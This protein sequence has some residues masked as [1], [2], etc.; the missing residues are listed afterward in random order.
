[1]AKNINFLG[2]VT[3]RNQELV[4]QYP[5]VNSTVA[6]KKDV[7]DGALPYAEINR[8][9]GMSYRDA[10][11]NT[12]KDSKVTEIKSIGENLIPYPYVDTNKTENGI[13]WTVNSDGTIL[14]SGVS[15]TSSNFSLFN[16]LTL[17]A[18]EYTAS[19]NNGLLELFKN[20]EFLGAA[21]QNLECKITIN[22]GDVL[23]ARVHF[24]TDWQAPDYAMTPMLNKGTTALSYIPYKEH[25]LSVSPTVQALNGYGLGVSADCHNYIDWEKKQFVKRVDK[26]DMGTL[27]W[28]YTN[29]FGTGVMCFTSRSITNAN[30]FG[31][32]VKPNAL[33]APYQAATADSIAGGRAD[34]GFTLYSANNALIVADS[35]YEDVTTFKAAMSGVLLV[36]ELATPEVIDISDLLT[37]SKMIDVQPNGSVVFVNEYGYDVP[38]TLTCYNSAQ[39]TIAGK[40]LGVAEKAIYDEDGEKLSKTRERVDELINKEIM[41]LSFNYE[42]PTWE[43]CTDTEGNKLNG[44]QT[45]IDSTVFDKLKNATSVKFIPYMTLVTRGDAWSN[46]QYHITKSVGILEFAQTDSPESNQ[47]YNIDGDIEIAAGFNS[48]GEYTY[49][50]VVSDNFYGRWVEPAI[51]NGPGGMMDLT[52]YK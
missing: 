50:I 28:S 24:S 47:I 37:T 8:V 39:Y 40:L 6:Y 23:S 25:T 29:A 17:P 2:N 20:S 32:Y 14:A 16:N 35:A 44:Y 52:F 49:A 43:P 7:P 34:K 5:A 41:T 46:G 11:T 31:A 48:I 30:F 26:V 51:Q 10:D 1:M 27:N 21:A 19:I 12:I 3:E 9:G 38:S 33:C 18:G 42:W 4:S 13:T 22:K 15:S 45:I 36:Y